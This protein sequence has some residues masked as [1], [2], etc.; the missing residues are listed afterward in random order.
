[1]ETINNIASG[2]SKTIWG[3][4]QTTG[5]EPISGQTGKGTVDSPY[6]QGNSETATATDPDNKPIGVYNEDKTPSTTKTDTTTTDPTS[7]S[8][9]TS[10]TNPADTTS[11][12]GGASHAT[13]TTGTSN[14]PKPLEETDKTGVTSKLGDPIKGTDATPS[15]AQ[16]NTGAPTGGELHQKQQGADRPLE[17]L[18]SK[19]E[20]KEDAEKTFKKDP[21]DHSGE[22]MKMH[23]GSEKKTET[24]TEG[25]KAKEAASKGTG[26]EYVKTSGLQA[27]GGDFDATK[28]GAGAEANRMLRKTEQILT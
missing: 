15:N 16:S 7:T 20:T 8:G 17:G 11:G 6:D 25:D 28:P 18:D 1:M 26:E 23:D 3:E 24:T 2:V 13:N 12:L 9:T 14:P 22:P 4:G 5:T 19:K 10:S 27:D 21:N